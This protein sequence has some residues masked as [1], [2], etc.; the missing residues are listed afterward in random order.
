M[1]NEGNN[2]RIV[3]E[4]YLAYQEGDIPALLKFLTDD[5]RWLE[6][7]PEDLIPTAG[8]RKGREQVKEFFATLDASEDVQSLIPQHFVAQGD[9]VV[10]LG[11][12]KSRVKS[13]G[14]LIKSPWVHVFTLSDGMIKEF[15]SFYD[16]A[17]A[18]KAYGTV[19]TASAKVGTSATR[20]SAIF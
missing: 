15:R 13:T 10:V 1:M 17:A 18:V 3:K 2:V 16:S 7:G 4:A 11:E 20:K 9:S 12:L 19:R 14:L 8:E 5:V 6:V